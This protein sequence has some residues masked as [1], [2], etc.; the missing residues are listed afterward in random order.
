[1]QPV[2]SLSWSRHRSVIWSCLGAIVFVSLAISASLGDEPARSGSASLPADHPPLS[3][4][5]PDVAAHGAGWDTRLPV[6][7]TEGLP[8]RVDTDDGPVWIKQISLDR[9]GDPYPKCLLCHDQIENIMANMGGSNLDCTFC[10]GGD[11]EAVTEELAHVHPTGEVVYNETIAPLDL[12]L[13]YQRFVNPSNLRVVD[14][15]CG[16][17]HPY[18]AEIIVKS[19]MATAAGH[20]AGGLYQNNVVDTKTP[21][22]GTFAVTDDDGFVP[23]E[24]GAVQS[25][26][27]LLIFDPT[28]DP[29]IIATHFAAVPSQACA[30]CHLWSRGKGYRGNENQNGLYRA[31]GCAACHMPYANDGFSLS[32]D[33]SID[34]TEPGH[35]MTHVVTKQIPTQQCLHCHHRGARIGLSFT[36]RAQMPPGLTSGPGVPGTTDEKFN[37]NY[38]YTLPDTNPQD[39]HGERGMHC[40]DCHTRAGIM[41]DGNIYGHMDQ[42][43]K[44]ECRQCHGLPDVLPDFRDHDFELLRGMSYDDPND[45]HTGPE[46]PLHEVTLVSKV[47]KEPHTVPVVMDIVNPISPKYNPRAACAM[48]GNHLKAQGGLECYACHAAWVPNCYG[49]HFERNEQLMGLNFV[50][51]LLEVGKVSTNNKIFESMRNFSIGPNSEGKVAPYLVACQPIADVT[52]PDGSKILDMVMPTTVNGL[53]GLAMNP[54]NPHTTRGAGEVRTCAECHRSPPTLGFGT[55]NYAIARTG[56]YTAGSGGV[57]VFD[58]DANPDQPVPA[59]SLQLVGPALAIASL[60]DVVEGVAAYLFVAQGPAGVAIFDRGDGAPPA[61]VHTITGVNAIDVSRVARYLYVVDEGV[62]VRIYDNDDPAMATLVATVPIPTALRAV[63]WGIHLFVAAGDRGLVVIDIADH[64]APF[65]AGALDTFD[66]VDVQLYAHFQN[67][68][69]FA[70]R[71][72]VADPS[73]GVRIV[74]LLP[75]FGSPRLVGG[76][77]AIGAQGLDA[78]TRY[79]LATATEPARE[80]D[81]LYVAAG[82]NGLRIFDMTNPEGVYEVGSVDTLGGEVTDVDVVSQLDPPGTNDYAICANA[83]FGLQIIGVNDPTSPVAVGSVPGASGASRVFTEVQQMDRF[84][85]EQGNTLKENSHPFTGTFTR[86]DIVRLL[87]TDI[88]CFTNCAG[89]LNNDLVVDSADLGLLIATFLTGDLIGDLNGDG[90]VDTA[91]LGMLISAF[92]SKCQ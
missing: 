8:I 40:I 49:C 57:Q 82:T 46:E 60:P 72:Y 34:H 55:G 78:Y 19:M 80:H 37:N 23:T 24:R 16:M 79:V 87:R 70:A 36:G 81:Y 32:A 50:T 31:D 43:T 92:G 13:A 2:Q 10:H 38:H 7:N 9:A 12:D 68:S 91:D 84:L 58:R 41:G 6:M 75:E 4:D 74:D 53:S 65:I 30:R 52:A 39:I 25:L 89:D 5:P 56:V 77:P 44:I 48:N 11:P 64:T 73:F 35:P 85:D 45:A 15:T 17:C 42:A 66:A 63:P 86:A 51:G 90:V 59:G 62:G 83:S 28:E 14:Q 61:P 67:T 27:N 69:K 71:A 88:G 54:V 22:F 33:M 47:T 76:I 18:S 29:S 21:I 3:V 26:E 1:M 20:Y